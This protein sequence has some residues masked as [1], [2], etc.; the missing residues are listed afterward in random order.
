MAQVPIEPKTTT[1]ETALREQ[2]ARDAATLKTAGQRAINL[3][4]ENTQSRAAMGILSVVLSVCAF[5]IVWAVI[6][7]ETNNKELMGLAISAL[8]LL[9]N[10]STAVLTFYFMRTNHTKQ[11]GVGTQED[12]DSR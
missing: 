3:I 10:M 11:G 2:G 6:H 8:V 4:W 1:D 9:T 12:K 5:V 7:F